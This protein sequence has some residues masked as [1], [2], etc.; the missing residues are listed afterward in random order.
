MRST[1]VFGALCAPKTPDL[2]KNGDI[3]RKGS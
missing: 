2:G 3:V 1:G